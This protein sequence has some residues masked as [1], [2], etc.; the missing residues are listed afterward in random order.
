[1]AFPRPTGPASPSKAASRR[2]SLRGAQVEKEQF[3]GYSALQ[4]LSLNWHRALS[5]FLLIAPHALLGVLAVILYKRRL[6]RGFPCFF[7][8][9]LYELAKFFPLFALYSVQGVG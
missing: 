5:L 2:S 9:V 4:M 1:M 7:V 3:Q 8:Y 6:Y